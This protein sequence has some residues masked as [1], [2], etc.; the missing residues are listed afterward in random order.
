MTFNEKSVRALVAE[1]A[2]KQPLRVLVVRPKVDFA[3]AMLMSICNMLVAGL[4]LMWGLRAL[5]ELFEVVPA[6][7]YVD[8]VFVI[9]GANALGAA[10][11]WSSVAVIK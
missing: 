3:P 10:F 4:M 11:G 8:S 9:M 2:E 5:H 1:E 7:G 6:G